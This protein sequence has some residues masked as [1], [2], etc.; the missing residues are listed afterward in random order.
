MKRD[1]IHHRDAEAP[2]EQDIFAASAPSAG[3]SRLTAAAVRKLGRVV[4]GP[5]TPRAAFFE[6]IF[7][8]SRRLGGGW[9]WR[10]P[11]RAVPL[12]LPVERNRA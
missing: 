1:E 6:G 3:N 8:V 9:I 12:R 2:R 5:G 7:S 10:R 4:E 11:H